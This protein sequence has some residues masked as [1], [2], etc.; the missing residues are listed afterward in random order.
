MH[1][2][3]KSTWPARAGKM[4]VLP[5]LL[6]VYGS[7]VPALAA[8]GGKG[9]IGD[10]G[11]QGGDGGLGDGNGATG[12]EGL[13]GGEAGRA[14]TENP[15]CEITSESNA[16]YLPSPDVAYVL[17]DA[18]PAVNHAPFALLKYHVDP[19]PRGS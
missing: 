4:Q 9:G 13:G 5:A 10:R 14:M 2:P 1:V 18:P 16:A 8:P 12:G 6:P 15:M 3:T 7:Q 19:K 17:P 11:G